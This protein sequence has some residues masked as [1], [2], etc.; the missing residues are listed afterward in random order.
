MARGLQVG[1]LPSGERKAGNGKWSGADA[2]GEEEGDWVVWRPG[3][4]LGAGLHKAGATVEQEEP[5]AG[6]DTTV[7]MEG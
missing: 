7:W 1:G 6:P 2:Q 5:E 4:Q 3:R